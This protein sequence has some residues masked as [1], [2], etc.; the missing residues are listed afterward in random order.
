[1]PTR[2]IRDAHDLIFKDDPEGLALTLHLCCDCDTRI[3]R[4]ISKAYDGDPC[5]KCGSHA[6]FPADWFLHNSPDY[7]DELVKFEFKKGRED[8]IDLDDVHRLALLACAI[9]LLVAIVL[10]HC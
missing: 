9:V 4:P 1:M 10:K 7:D 6:V 2:P 5:Y 8:Y 3:V